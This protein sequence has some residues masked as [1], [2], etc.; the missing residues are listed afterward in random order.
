MNWKVLRTSKEDILRDRYD[1]Q[2]LNKLRFALPTTAIAKAFDPEWEQSPNYPSEISDSESERDTWTAPDIECQSINNFSIS[3]LEFLPE[4][5]EDEPLCPRPSPEIGAEGIE[6][7]RFSK[8]S[9]TRIRYKEVFKRL[10]SAPIFSALKVNTELRGL[11]AHLTF[12]TEQDGLLGTIVH[13]LLFQRKAL[14]K[15]IIKDVAK[16]HPDASSEPSHD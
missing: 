13:G 8:K 2:V 7:H 5:K 9:W 1:P 14:S 16:A 10:R 15:E 6:C 3:E 11:K 12:Y 4:V